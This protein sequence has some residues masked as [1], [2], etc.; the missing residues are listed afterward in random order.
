MKKVLGIALVVV[1]T[2]GLV[3]W[4]MADQFTTGDAAVAIPDNSMG[5][6]TACQDIVVPGPL[7]ITDTPS[8][9]VG[10]DHSWVG[11]LTIELRGPL[12]TL[13]VMNRPGRSGTGAGDS[14]DAD[15][16]ISPIMFGAMAPSGVDAEEVGNDSTMADTGCGGADD[17]GAN[18][19]VDNFTPN[20]DAADTP[21]AGQGTDFSDFTG[22]DAAG[23]WTLCIS[24]SAGGDTGTLQ[25]WSLGFNG[26]SVPV[27]LISFSV[28]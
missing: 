10:V 4:A 2:V 20:P 22:T 26:M 21:N 11:D 27:E 15:N 5:V 8:V 3:G 9:S 14:S 6:I 16:A 28:D 24:D 12:S 17:V 13:T 19:C 23:T 7:M 1:S 25:T 18:D